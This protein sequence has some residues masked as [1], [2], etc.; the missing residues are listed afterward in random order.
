LP[1][2][3]SPIPLFP[4]QREP[5]LPQAYGCNTSANAPHCQQRTGPRSRY[6]SACKIHVA[7]LKSCWALV[8]TPLVPARVFS[9]PQ[10]Q[11]LREPSDSMEKL[12]PCQSSRVEVRLVLSSPHHGYWQRKVSL[13]HEQPTRLVPYACLTPPPHSVAALDASPVHGWP[14]DA[15]GTHLRSGSGRQE[16]HAGV[17]CC[18]FCELYSRIQVHID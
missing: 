2:H 6:Q 16:V 7:P 5:S 18:T 4:Q 17:T 13:H 9:F 11:E 15:R 10:E 8:D 12:T 3:H 14:N 1:H